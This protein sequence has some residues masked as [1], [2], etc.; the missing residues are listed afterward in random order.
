MKKIIISSIVFFCLFSNLSYGEEGQEQVLDLG[1]VIISATKTERTVGEVPAV[2]EVITKEVIEARG[3]KTLQDALKLI[4]A[5]KVTEK[6]GHWGEKGQVQIMGLDAKHT[7]VLMNGQK[8]L[9]GHGATDL[10]SYPI[11]MIER[12]E[13]VKGPFSALYGSEAI[14]GVVNIITKSPPAKPTV[15]ASTAFGSDNTQVHS[16]SAGFR[17][18]GSGAFLNYTYRKS[19]GVDDDYDRYNEHMFQGNLQYEFPLHIKLSFKPYYS[20][21]KM[22]YGDRRQER[23]GLNTTGEWLP[24]EVSKLTA[25]GSWFYHKHYTKNRMTDYVYDNYEGEILY[26]REIPLLGKHLLTGGYN[27]LFE[28]VDDGGKRYKADAYTHGFFFQDEWNIVK[29]LS[30]VLGLRVDDHK[31]WDTQVNPK[32]SF[33]FNLL[34]NLRLLGSVG[35]AFK[36]PPM[37]RLYAGGWRMGPYIVHANP[38]LEPEKSIGYQAGLEYTHGNIFQGKAVYFRNDVEDLISYRIVRPTRRPPWNLYWIN[39]DKAMTQGVELKLTLHPPFRP[40]KNLMTSLGYTY[41]DTENK[42]MNKELPLRPN[43]K[44]DFEIQYDIPRFAFKTALEV[45][46]IGRRYEDAA[47]T[48]RLGDYALVNLAFT[49]K[50]T[51]IKGLPVRPE[52]FLRIDNLLGKKNISDEYDIDGF[53][54]FGGLKLTF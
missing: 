37:V 7:L 32:G 52:L 46:Y 3:V 2:V 22:Q 1:K 24:D 13:V 21:H 43:H 42:R 23:V 10:Q 39:I 25:S 47:N 33:S 12:I 9:G 28:K 38:N 15:S 35:K 14:G 50:I 4:P 27:Y 48:I 36:S 20:E 54:I 11:E 30:F 19:D 53:N 51:E 34:K 44:L 40:L 49:K 18:K 31:E 8:V 16:S 6:V 17:Y 41:L 5:L 26:S 45:E 29:P